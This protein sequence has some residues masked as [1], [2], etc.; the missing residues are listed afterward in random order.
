MPIAK[1]ADSPGLTVKSATSVLV[2]LADE[3]RQ[4]AGPCAYLRPVCG[5]SGPLSQC[6]RR[7]SCPFAALACRRGCAG[8]LASGGR[9]WGT[10]AGCPALSLAV[11]CCRHSKS[12]WYMRLHALPKTCS[13]A[14]PLPHDAAGMAHQTCQRPFMRP[15]L[16]LLFTLAALPLERCMHSPSS[17]ALAQ[18]VTLPW[19]SCCWG[20][21]L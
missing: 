4:Q 11:R 15:S 18:S 7:L 12:A 9:S 19:R 13:L 20:Q 6:C 8:A 3:C 10:T 16:H 14:W 5:P 1:F 2:A 21:L 17:T